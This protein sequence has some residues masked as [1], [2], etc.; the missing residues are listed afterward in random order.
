MND[1][2]R[3]KEQLIHE[4]TVLRQQVSE[5]RTFESEQ[6]RA[7]EMLQESEEKYRSLVESTDD[8]IYLVDGKGTFLFMN[9]KH[10]SRLGLEEGSCLGRTYRE[11][12]LPEET[13]EFM[14]QIE[15]VFRT[16]KSVQRE[17]KSKRDDRCF[18]RTFSPV[19]KSNNLTMAVTVISKDI[20]EL[21]RMEEK[22]KTQ[23]LTDELTGI[24]NRRGFFTLVDQQLKLSKRAQKGMFMLYVDVDN[25]KEINDTLGHSEGDVALTDTAKI[26]RSNYRESDIIARIGGDEFV[27]I[28]VGTEGDNIEK[29]T[30][31]LRGI[32]QRHNS[33]S[34]RKFKLSLSVG[35]AYYDASRPCT[36]D[37]LLVLG[38][39][40]MYRQKRLK[41]KL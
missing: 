14:E 4:L 37:E 3:T 13:T 23:S 39:S 7:A 30:E 41:Q 8:S 33:G 31:R 24:Y 34:A 11:F 38:D 25:L 32:I 12:H 9:K 17:H 1:E 5:L 10:L 6:K 2:D 27:V 28:P 40:S 20:T 35:V 16:G 21:K 36:I 22:L 18:L 15:M 19:K 29:I 26:L